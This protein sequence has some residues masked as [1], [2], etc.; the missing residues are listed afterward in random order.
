MIYTNY[1]K[2]TLSPTHEAR[3]RPFQKRENI[4][5]TAKIASVT[6]ILIALKDSANVIHNL[7]QYK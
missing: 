3:A 4:N 1:V 5:I 7:S 2:T 6:H